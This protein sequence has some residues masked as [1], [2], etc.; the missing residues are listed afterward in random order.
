MEE[1]NH[2]SKSSGNNWIM[3]V[4]ILLLGVAAGAVVMLVNTK[5]PKTNW[6]MINYNVQIVASG[7]AITDFDELAKRASGGAAEVKKKYARNCKL[8]ET[9]QL[10]T[11]PGIPAVFSSGLRIPDFAN[12][13]RRQFRMDFIPTE[14]K[15]RITTSLVEYQNR[16]A[17]RHQFDLGPNEVRVI[18]IHDGKRINGVYEYAIIKVCPAQPFPSVGNA[19]SGPKR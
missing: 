9:F 4:S 11:T 12:A 8:E 2:R 14:T 16:S 18:A 19:L 17:T 7:E 1:Q 10:N 15:G 13:S 5:K 6:A 3:H